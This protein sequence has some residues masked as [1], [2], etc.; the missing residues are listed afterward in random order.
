MTFTKVAKNRDWQ[1]SFYSSV[2]APYYNLDMVFET[3]GNGGT[4]LA[5]AE[6]KKPKVFSN[7]YIDFGTGA[8]YSYTQ[9][10]SKY[11]ISTSGQVTC[12]GD[13]NR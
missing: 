4:G 2:V 10:H 12:F 9:D 1:V 11:G 3:W 13:I 6:C 7:L 5:P 8:S